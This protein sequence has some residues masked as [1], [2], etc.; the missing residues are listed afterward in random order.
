MSLRT[1][2]QER[3]EISLIMKGS[4][5]E[6][7]MSLALSWS[8]KWCLKDIIGQEKTVFIKYSERDSLKEN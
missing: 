8:I 2:N 6:E 3:K 7:E 1:Y 5:V 4:N